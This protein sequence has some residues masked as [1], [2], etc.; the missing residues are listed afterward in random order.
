MLRPKFSPSQLFSWI[1]GVGTPF[2]NGNF[3]FGE[4][5]MFQVYVCDGPIKMAHCP[6][7]KK[8]KTWEAT[9]I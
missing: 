2:A 3:Y 1:K 8:K 5:P 4:P 9:P 6:P 7:K